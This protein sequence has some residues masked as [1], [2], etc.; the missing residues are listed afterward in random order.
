MKFL[1]KV[2]W[3]IRRK[4]KKFPRKH[5]QSLLMSPIGLHTQWEFNSIQ[6]FLNWLIW[7][8]SIFLLKC[9]VS[10]N[11]V[12]RFQKL[13]FPFILQLLY[14]TIWTFLQKEFYTLR[15]QLDQEILNICNG[16]SSE[17]SL[18]NPEKVEKIPMRTFT[19]S[20]ISITRDS[21]SAS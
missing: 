9:V 17:D 20:T 10:L 21:H 4:S 1:M 11:L 15:T 6:N 8:D 12:E 2:C 19:K 13:I 16:I 18:K 7:F 14:S 5:L 3:E